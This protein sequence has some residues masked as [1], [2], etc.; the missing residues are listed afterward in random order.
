MNFI[1]LPD[2]Q[3]PVWNGGQHYVG[4]KVQRITVPSAMYRFGI[5]WKNKY[6]E[7]IYPGKFTIRGRDI[8]QH[9]TKVFDTK[10]GPMTAYI[11]PIENLNTKLDEIC[12]PHNA[13]KLKDGTCPFEIKETV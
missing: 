5:A 13:I 8:V 6:G 12:I 9:Q 2:I 3:T 4:I 1:E 11:I 10:Y 7:Q